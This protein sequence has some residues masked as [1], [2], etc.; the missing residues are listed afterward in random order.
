[1]QPG[2]NWIMHLR[3][4]IAKALQERKKRKIR[5]DN[6][7]FSTFS[8]GFSTAPSRYFPKAGV[9]ILV[10]IKLFDRACLFCHY[11]VTKIV[12]IAKNAV[13]KNSS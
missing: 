11:F 13:E 4:H 5:A 7:E 1:M 2:K 3:M 6:N 9:C 8:T 12:T 10:Y